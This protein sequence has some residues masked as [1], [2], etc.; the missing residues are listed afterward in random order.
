MLKNDENDGRRL[1]LG[2]QWQWPTVMLVLLLTAC[3]PRAKLPP[4]EKPLMSDIVVEDLATPITKEPMR[5]VVITEKA[6]LDSAARQAFDQAVA[7]LLAGELDAAIALLEPL[8]DA[9]PGVTAPYIDLACVYR[10]RGQ[11][12]RAEGL[13]KKALE[14]VPGHPVASN[15]YGLLLR[16]VGRFAEAR[17]VYG[18]SLELYPDYLPIR[19]NLGILCDL[20]LNDMECAFEQYSYY[21][22]A[23]PD[24][25]QAALWVSEL[26]MR[27]GQ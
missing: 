6:T 22:A 27:L 8:V 14:L 9:E 26:Q 16:S 11:L 1:C 19:R 7:M 20:Y 15:E 10:K 5:G 23:R 25:Q 12:E 21:S 17:D 2:C 13:L 4:P 3:V 24:D 18:N